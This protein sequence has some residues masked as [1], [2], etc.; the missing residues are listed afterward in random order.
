[1]IILLFQISPPQLYIINEHHSL[2]SEEERNK[3]L[4]LMV[5][6]AVSLGANRTE[7]KNQLQES[8]EFEVELANVR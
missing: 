5:N 7:A 4:T 2:M 1:M 6:I 8:L 3:Y